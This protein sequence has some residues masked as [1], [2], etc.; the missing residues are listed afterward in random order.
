MCLNTW[1]KAD[2]DHARPLAGNRIPSLHSMCRGPIAATAS[3]PTAPVNP[4]SDAR[5]ST[6]SLPH[7]RFLIGGS[8]EVGAVVSDLPYY[9]HS[10]VTARSA[11]N[12][13]KCS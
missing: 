2:H 9:T 4:R 7:H 3:V 8:D 5:P 11:Q 6:S 13:A 1:H 10:Q 12:V